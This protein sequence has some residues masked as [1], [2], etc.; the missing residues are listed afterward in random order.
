MPKQKESLST[1][2]AKLVMVVSLIAGIGAIVGIMGYFWI[3]P[4][5]EVVIDGGIKKEE[6]KKDFKLQDLLPENAQIIEEKNIDDKIISNRKIVIWMMNQQK[7]PKTND[8]YTCPEI[9]RGSYY[10]G[11]VKVSLVDLSNMKII[12]T[13]EIAS[14]YSSINEFD[15]PYQI[16]DDAGPY[17]VRETAEGREGVPV[18]IKLKDY[19]HDGRE[20]EFAFFDSFSCISP[21]MAIIGYSEKQDKVIQY[22][23]NLR[24]KSNDKITSKSNKW[25]AKIFLTKIN[26]FGYWEAESNTCGRGGAI[27]KSKISFN[28]EKEIFEGEI[29]IIDCENGFDIS[30]WKTYR[31]EEYGLEFKYPK[32]W[33]VEN[34]GAYEMTL[35]RSL[36]V[37]GLNKAGYSKLPDTD[38]PNSANFYLYKS[39]TELDSKKISIISLKDY[40]DKY[41]T[42]SDPVYKNVINKKIG[43]LDGYEA[44]AGPNQFGGGK[45]YFAELS[46]K[47]IVSFWLFSER[48]DQKIMDQILSTFKFIE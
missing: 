12:N 31:N 35:S 1:S 40:L 30:D 4:K 6:V 38:M 5:S 16:K 14:P 23:F 46:N 24:E 34:F 33:A 44:D 43:S 20:L 18:I 8:V 47:Q 39:I 42:L 7:N 28:K 48:T 2:T 10:T 27:E 36:V 25:I 32:D 26:N 11:L 19:N 9:T 17:F 41:S 29:E 3:M 45:Y 37:I 21:S 13:V 15:V 22:D